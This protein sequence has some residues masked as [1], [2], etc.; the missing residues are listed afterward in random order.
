MLINLT[1]RI[2]LKKISQII[3]DIISL[4]KTKNI[5]KQFL[6][7]IIQL[8]IKNIFKQFLKAKTFDNFFFVKKQF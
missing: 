5:F 2:K 3:F 6:L 8:S 1:K 7:K 4:L